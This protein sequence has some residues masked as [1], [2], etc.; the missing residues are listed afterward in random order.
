MRADPAQR[1]QSHAGLGAF[2]LPG[3]HSGLSH[4]CVPHCLLVVMPAAHNTRVQLE[5]AAFGR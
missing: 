2:V 1:V 3:A 4:A 5:L